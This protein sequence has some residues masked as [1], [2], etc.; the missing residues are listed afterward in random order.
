MVS[1]SMDTSSLAAGASIVQFSLKLQYD[2]Q[3]HHILLLRLS[4]SQSGIFNINQ[5]KLTR[6]FNSQISDSATSTHLHLPSLQE[7]VL[8]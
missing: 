2:Q 7:G 5:F 4:S 1:I 6:K 3:K 8:P